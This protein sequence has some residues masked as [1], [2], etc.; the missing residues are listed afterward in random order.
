MPTIWTR[1]R[2]A[3]SRPVARVNIARPSWLM[4]NNDSRWIT[5]GPQDT[6]VFSSHPIPGNE[7]AVARVRSSLARQGATIVH[8]GQVDVHTTGHGKRQELLALHAVANPELFIPVHGEYEH[9][10]AHADLAPIA[11]CPPRISSLSPT[12]I[13]CC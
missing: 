6:V 7:A 13:K 3:S 4:A 1:S 12:A 10:L 11:A 8:S 2:P 9:L 5:I